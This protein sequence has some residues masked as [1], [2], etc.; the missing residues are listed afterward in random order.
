AFTHLTGYTLEECIGQSPRDLI[1]S[2]LETT[3]FFENLW[4]TITAG[5]TWHSEV[6][7]RR[8][9]GT[10]YTEEQTVTPVRNEAGEITHFISIKQDISDRKRAEAR[11]NH[12]N[13]ELSRWVHERS[14]QLDQTQIRMEA[15]LNYSMDGLLLAW[16]DCH[17]Q[18]TNPAFNTLL[19]C[20]PG[21][22]LNQSLLNLIPPDERSR[23]EGVLQVVVG[24]QTGKRLEIPI[25]RLD[26]TS[27]E[28]E[29]SIG[30]VH[31][32]AEQAAGFVCA[33]RDI[34]ERNQTQ[35]ALAEERNLLRTLIDTAPEF[36]YIKDTQ[37]RFILSNSAHAEAR[38]HT[39]PEE[40][41]G[42]TDADYFAPEHAEQ[43]KA[44]EEDI[45]RTGIPM[46]DYEQPSRGVR[47][48]DIWISLNK[49]PL[50]N[51]KGEIIGLVCITHDITERKQA[52]DALRRSEEQLRESQRI[53]QTVL[54][55]IPVRVFWKDRHSMYLGCNQLFSQDAGITDTAAIIGKHDRD[56]PWSESE[57]EIYLARDE[58]VMGSGIPVLAYETTNTLA[59]GT[60]ITVQANKLPLRD[61]QGQVIGLIGAYTDITERKRAEDALRQSEE[62]LR[63]SQQMLQSVLDTIPIGVFW[64]DRDSV[65]QGCS[66]HYAEDAGLTSPAEII[67][68]RDHD[69]PWAGDKADNY[70][71][72]D[73]EILDK[74]TP[75]IAF[76]DQRWIARD[77]PIWTT[78]T[79]VPLRNRDG[80]I[81][82]ILGAY[83]DITQRIEA[84]NQLRLYAAEVA[85]L[86]NNAPC[87]YHSLDANGLIVRIN[88][89]ELKWLG[90]TREEVQGKLSFMDI[91]TAKS[92]QTF[93]ENFPVFMKRGWVA[94]LEMEFIRKDGSIIPTLVSATAIYDEQGK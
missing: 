84:E 4:E 60:Q 63:E 66:R 45:F 41:I 6:I 24:E 80:Q 18:Q 85:D 27:F 71:R 70:I 93:A 39:R 87:G 21:A 90:Y 88:D 94:D 25:I 51:L 30:Y 91:A 86:Y 44:E 72:S 73:R 34:T 52:E 69:L 48:E 47:D 42:K 49:V 81:V 22:Y 53:L 35:R 26:G 89:M 64:K 78:T 17:I 65:Y 3:M 33:I 12:L 36:I 1:H 28:A 62:R 79:K 11:I 55:T 75:K 2:G 15:I 31:A 14:V 58:E 74:G 5:K 68:K 32:G 83:M 16:T 37:H 50:R 10:L 23:V 13:V 76:E 57:I 20:Q 29:L 9:D 7:N 38:G 54:D 67:G 92:K 59:D 19:G 46:I 8:K 82:G 56:L 77:K 61:A 43:F 40:M